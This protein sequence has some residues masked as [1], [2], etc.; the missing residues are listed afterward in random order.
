MTAKGPLPRERSQPKAPIAL[1]RYAELSAEI[2]AGVPEKEILERESITEETWA[3]A[4]AFWLKRMADEAA[5]KRFESTTRYQAIFKAKRAIFDSKLRRERDR[6]SRA[7]V[8]A[9]T[10]AAL[11]AADR[12]LRAPLV[13]NL[14]PLSLPEAPPSTVPV[15][16]RGAAGS[17][18]PSFLNAP[19]PA[20]P[21][22]AAP[23]AYAGP[24]AY[25][26][27]QP[28]ISANST[29]PVGP[30]PRQVLPFQGGAAAPPPARVAAP[31]A[32]VAPA[33]NPAPATVP[34]P[35][36]RKVWGTMVADAS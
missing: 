34:E 12:E 20:K 11:D 8:E 18:A 31:P 28:V 2:D 14:A 23:P 15:P 1:E 10:S 29:G 32:S 22:P 6:S 26:P 25:V 35:P 21:M 27:P 5:R 16:A 24:P 4:K 30:I 19:T 3:A 9:P 7:K 13:S 17:P 36:P 33:T